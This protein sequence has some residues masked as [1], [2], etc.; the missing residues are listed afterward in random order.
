MPTI[1]VHCHVVPEECMGMVAQGPDG[2]EYGIR[3]EPGPDGR[4]RAI[5][6]GFPFPSLDPEQMWNIDRRLREMDAAGVGV[7]V[8]SVP[9]FCFYYALGAEQ[10]LAFARRLNDGIDAI[11]RSHPRRFVG[12]ATVPLQD[13]ALAVTE[14]DRAVNDLGLRGVAIASNVAGENLDSPRLFPFFERVAALRLPVFIHPNAV[15]AAGRLRDYYLTN[16][17]GNPMDTTIAAASLVFGA[18]LARLPDLA[19]ILAHGGGATPFICG[20]WGHGWQVRPEPKQLLAHPPIEDVRRFY[21]DT[22]THDRAALD[23]LVNAFGDDHVLIGTDYPF[24]M[25]DTTPL[26]TITAL[27]LPEQGRE[28]ILGGTAARLFGVV[29][30]R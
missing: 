19:V 28:R 20:R 16:L 10:A 5:I 17:V 14:L 27:S 7:Q 30:N 13:T 12:M 8:L 18:V 1:D 23:Y 21:F 24:D 2:R 15:A 11:V 3:T 26:D 6:D 25:G 22:I 4:G 29:A 9:P